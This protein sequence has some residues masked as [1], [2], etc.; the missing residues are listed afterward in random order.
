MFLIYRKQVILFFFKSNP[1][2][3]TWTG[4]LMKRREFLKY[5]GASLAST[6]LVTGCAE[7]N[8]DNEDAFWRQGNFP[9]VSE[10]VTITDL[11][12]EGSIPLDLNGY[13]YRN[14]PN[15]WK[16]P[17]RHFFFG[18]G[19]IHG[20]KIEDGQA[21]WYRNRYVQ[22]PFLYGE[23]SNFKTAMDPAAN[24]S[25]VS[26]IYH[27]GKLLSLGEAGL[28]YEIDP[29]ELTTKAPHDYQGKL[30]GAMTAHPKIDPATGELLFFG[31]NAVRPYL[32]YYRADASGALVQK[33]VL[34]TAGPALMHDFAITENYVIFLELPVVFSWWA[35]LKGEALPFVWNEDA[36]SRI[37]VMP[38]TGS[39]KDLKWFEIDPAFVFHVMNAYEQGNDVMLDVARY[40]HLWVNGSSD[41]DYPAR[42]SRYTLGMKTGH[43]SLQEIGPQRMEFPQV[44]RELTGRNYRYG[45]SL[46]VVIVG[47]GANKYESIGSVIKHDM[48]SGDVQVFEVGG[49]EI[50]GEP[51][52]VPTRQA[53]NEDDGYVLSYVYSPDTHSTSL[54]IMDGHNISNVL[55][56]VQLAARVPQG[57]HG[58]WLPMEEMHG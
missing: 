4:N 22:T 20:V 49:G 45:Y 50:P 5:T 10:E 58:L 25:N 48:L 7:E 34:E 37:G 52:F 53:S 51:F 47:T 43:S 1:A 2:I 29:E 13:Y 36:P 9:P 56:K 19:M 32:T 23:S 26:V 35:M 40:D 54:W 39:S 18:D 24:Q 27:G 46:G 44:N 3:S 38:R 30:A 14:G 21:R 15:N 31:Y 55:A 16:G 57:F 28:P 33:E 42:L 11:K 12:V 41:F 8:A 17:S 6:T